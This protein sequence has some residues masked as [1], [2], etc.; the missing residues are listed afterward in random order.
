MFTI[1]SAGV[2]D[3][4][5]LYDVCLKTG[6]S[7]N[8]ATGLHVSEEML[9]DVYVGP[10]LEFAS[11][12]SFALKDDMGIGIGY[13]LSVL[14]T[15]LFEA[16]TRE[17]WWP[18]IQEKY[19]QYQERRSECWLIEEIYNPSPSP[20]H[21]LARYPSHGHI[22][23]LAHAQGK[24]FGRLMMSKM[25]SCLAELGSKGFHLRVSAQNARALAFYKALGYSIIDE[26]PSVI[27]VGKRFHQ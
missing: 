1:E 5:D 23:L 4:K 13:A 17:R 27:T 12:T 6:N 20:Q 10:Y 18:D 14:D 25:E 8:D 9:G 3:Q 19:G 22:D 16:I 7:G 11:E 2:K 21:L 26:E 24:G 15:N